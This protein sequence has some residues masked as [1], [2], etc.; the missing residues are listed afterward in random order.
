M[1]TTEHFGCIQ[2]K[3]EI[4]EKNIEL[5]VKSRVSNLIIDSY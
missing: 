3:A 5:K 4:K 1:N 2:K